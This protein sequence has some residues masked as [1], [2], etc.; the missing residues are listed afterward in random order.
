[1]AFWVYILKC[2]DGSHYIGHMDDLEKRLRQHKNGIESSYTSKR[3]PIALVFSE[4]LNSR[5]EALESERRIKGWGRKKKEALIRGDWEEIPR[6]SKL[7]K[8]G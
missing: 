1:M 7:H 6:L 8:G 2:S 4:S 3:R 5:I